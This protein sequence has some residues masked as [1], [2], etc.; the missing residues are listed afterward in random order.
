MRNDRATKKFD[1]FAQL[2]VLYKVLSIVYG[3]KFRAKGLTMVTHNVAADNMTFE[4]HIKRLQ[5]VLKNF[6]HSFLYKQ[7]Y[8]RIFS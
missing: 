6:P 5:T 7:N 3:C 2:K 4:K 8:L 1:L